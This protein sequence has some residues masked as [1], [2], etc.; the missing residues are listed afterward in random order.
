MK[1]DTV[2]LTLGVVVA[3]IPFLG[4]PGAW[5][6]ALSALAGVGIVIAIL[7]LRRE[8]M[9]RPFSLKQH[10]E[11][12]SDSFTQNGF[13]HEPHERAAPPASERVSAS[14]TPRSL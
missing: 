8:M 4:F 5:E 7:L 3:A 14:E 1:K 12:R 2:I 10:L 13:R 6:N 9:Q 11:M